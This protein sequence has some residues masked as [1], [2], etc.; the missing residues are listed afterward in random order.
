MTNSTLKFEINSLPLEMRAEVADFI[1]FLK[2][3]VKKEHNIKEREF[4]F[5]KGKISISDDFD[6]PLD[7]SKNIKLI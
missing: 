6:A 4:G 3:K 5:A 1:A 7:D 2:N